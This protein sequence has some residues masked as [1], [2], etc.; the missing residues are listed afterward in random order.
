MELVEL[1]RVSDVDGV[2]LTEVESGGEDYSTW[3]GRGG[4]PLQQSLAAAL[5]TSVRIPYNSE[6]LHL[7]DGPL[8]FL[9]CWW[10]VEVVVCIHLRLS[11]Q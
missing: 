3:A 8:G 11:G 9:F 5:S 4:H 1:L 6:T 2:G 10:H 7:F